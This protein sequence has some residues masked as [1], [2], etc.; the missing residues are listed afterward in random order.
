MKKITMKDRAQARKYARENGLHAPSTDSDFR[1]ILACM[2]GEPA[3]AVE[4]QPAPEPAIEP[5][6]GP[7][8]AQVKESL[9]TGLQ[10]DSAVQDALAQLTKALT[11]PPQ[12]APQLDENRIIEL[13]HQHA[14]RSIELIDPKTNEPKA[15]ID[16]PHKAL[17]DVYTI[18]ANGQHIYLHGAAGTGKTTL[19]QQLA[20]ML[21][22]KFYSTGAVL[23]KYE[24]LGF[25]DANSNYQPTEFY[26]AYTQGGVFLFDELDASAPAAIVALNQALANPVYTFPNGE[27]KRHPDFIAVGAGNTD[28][29]GASRAYNARNT[30]DASSVDR[31]FFFH[32]DYDHDIEL[33]QAKRHLNEDKARHL[34]N[35]I[36]DLRER[37]KSHKLDTVVFSTRTI[38][39]YALAV[40]AGM[41]EAQAQ[42]GAFPPMSQDQKRQLGLA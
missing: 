37:A 2:T 28:L 11:P 7:T 41:S 3:P 40:A 21:D 23:Q 24:L 33:M 9:K 14:T 38:Q 12:E 39:K 26:K 27:Q 31:F 32:I 19:A 15:K 6:P 25:N 30:L 29:T 16:T 42:L 4:P 17:E 36:H 13:I 1:G 35:Q 22:R 5:A 34:V 20:E 8:K 10:D 18:A